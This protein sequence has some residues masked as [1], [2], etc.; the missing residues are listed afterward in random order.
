MTWF[1]AFTKS[2]TATFRLSNVERLDGREVLVPCEGRA[3]LLQVVHTH[4]VIDLGRIALLGAIER[5]LGQVGLDLHYRLGVGGGLRGRLAIELEHLRD[6]L[7]KFL[8]QLDRL[9]VGL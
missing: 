4:L 5:P 9:R 2:G 8:A 3:E 7:L 6:V 1:I